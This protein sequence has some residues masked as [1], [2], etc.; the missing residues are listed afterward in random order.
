MYIASGQFHTVL[1]SEDGEHIW[2]FGQNDCGQLGHGD[3]EDR[4]VPT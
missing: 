4:D 2:T 3:N 1:V